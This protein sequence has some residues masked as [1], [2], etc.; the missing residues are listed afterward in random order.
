M[1]DENIALF[2]HWANQY[3]QSVMDGKFPFIGYTA[4]LN[5]AFSEAKIEPVMQVL[6][7]GTGTGNLAG[8]FLLAGCQVWGMDFSSGMLAQTKKKWPQIQTVQNNLLSDWS[9]PKGLIFDRIVSAY[10]FHQFDLAHKI[11][12]VKKAR[13]FLTQDG[14]LVIADISYP[15]VAARQSAN[16]RL[17]ID[18]DEN[19]YYWAADESI[20]SCDR[21][22]IEAAYQQVSDCAGIYTFKFR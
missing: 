3:D 22:G 12:L 17:K 21:T 13:Q 18:W 2:D 14:W 8:R 15:T 9:F 6:D 10:V 5:K 7:L 19:E 1:A 11:A 4:V 16:E 20:Q